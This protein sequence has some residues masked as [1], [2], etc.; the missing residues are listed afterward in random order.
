[1]VNNHA[2]PPGPGPYGPGPGMYGPPGP[3]PYGPNMYGP[4]RHMGP[5]PR[6]P[7]PQGPQPRQQ[8]PSQLN[9]QQTKDKVDASPKQMNVVRPQ[10]SP[11]MQSPRQPNSYNA[12]GGHQ[13]FMNKRM[14][15][16]Q[17]VP[18]VIGRGLFMYT[19]LFI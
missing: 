6:P 4:Y 3:G 1:M 8:Q 13:N 18:L 15:K 2:P 10:G 17:V 5:G 19:P 12:Y 16:S 9:A 14:Y 11:H 7:P